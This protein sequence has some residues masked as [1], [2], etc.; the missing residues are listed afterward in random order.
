ME[1][2]EPERRPCKACKTPLTFVM[3]PAGKIIPL[4]DRAPVY[5][6]GQDMLGNPVAMRVEDAFVS[7]FSSCP[8][9]SE[10]SRKKPR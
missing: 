6:V 8:H 5:R 2:R 7:H 10:F 1:P 4:D 9:A 3:G